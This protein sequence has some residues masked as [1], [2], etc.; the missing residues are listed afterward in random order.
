MSEVKYRPLGPDEVI[1]EGDERLLPGD[2]DWIAIHRMDVGFIP[3]DIPRAKFRRPINVAL[4]ESANQ[5]KALMKPTDDE[6]NKAVAEALGWTDCGRASGILQRPDGS[7]DYPPNFCNDLNAC[8]EMEATLSYCQQ[9]NFVDAL[10][11]IIN[12]EPN[13]DID[14]DFCSDDGWSLAAA[15]ARQRTE[16]FLR[17]KGLWGDEWN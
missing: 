6:I 14:D 5:R 1:Q 17:T 3:K 2:T 7:H 10:L 11:A 16:A 15:T 12:H 8:A 9:M 4:R 13:Y